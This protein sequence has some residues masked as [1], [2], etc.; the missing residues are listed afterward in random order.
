MQE[1][2]ATKL[3]SKNVGNPF[4]TPLEIC[5]QDAG[6]GHV[7]NLAREEDEEP[8]RIPSSM[9]SKLKPHQVCLVK[10]SLIHVH[11]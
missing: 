5:L 9:S 10:I 1:Q 6:D 4:E 2:S 11:N 7:V 3:R 8:V